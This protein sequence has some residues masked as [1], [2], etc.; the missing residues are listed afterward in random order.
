VKPAL[1]QISPV[2]LAGLLHDE[3]VK[4][5]DAAK[6]FVLL[7]RRWVVER[8]FAWLGPA[9]QRLAARLASISV[10]AEFADDPVLIQ[11]ILQGSNG[12]EFC[13]A[14]VDVTHR[15][16]LGLVDDELPVVD[17]V[18][19]GRQPALLDQTTPTECRNYIRNAGYVQS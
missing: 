11:F 6:G 14:P 15:L 8:T 4:R 19:Q 10:D 1:T 18:S 2:Y 3:I 5:S 12:A 17:V 16:S 7:P 13:I 9:G